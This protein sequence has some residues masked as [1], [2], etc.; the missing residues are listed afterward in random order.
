ME[1]GFKW[2]MSDLNM[3]GIPNSNSRTAVETDATLR[4]VQDQSLDINVEF[5]RPQ[6]EYELTLNQA[7]VY[8]AATG[9]LQHEKPN[10]TTK[11]SM[12]EGF[13]KAMEAFREAHANGELRNWVQGLRDTFTRFVPVATGEYYKRM[14]AYRTGYFD[15]VSNRNLYNDISQMAAMR[16]IAEAVGDDI[17]N[18][19]INWGMTR[20]SN[21]FRIAFDRAKWNSVAQQGLPNAHMIWTGLPTFALAHNDHDFRDFNNL[22]I[23]YYVH[24]LSHPELLNS[25]GRAGRT[26]GGDRRAGATLDRG[27]GLERRTPPGNA[28]GKAQRGS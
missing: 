21:S 10:R 26:G 19:R 12:G 20:R 8:E 14:V 6:K 28:Y 4:V 16:P 13:L 27:P 2:P 5:L 1:D 23:P 24:N 18:H 11:R 3:T 15:A 25:R 9:T 7:F 17:L 22:D